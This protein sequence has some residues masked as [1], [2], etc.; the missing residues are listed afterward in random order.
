MVMCSKGWLLSGGM[1]TEGTSDMP[2]F[3]NDVTYVLPAI[4]FDLSGT[5][6]GTGTRVGVEVGVELGTGVGV[7]VR[8]DTKIDS[9]E[10]LVQH[11]DQTQTHGSDKDQGNG[12]NKENGWENGGFVDEEYLIHGCTRTWAMKRRYEIS[13]VYD[14]FKGKAMTKTTMSLS[15]IPGIN[16]IAAGTAVAGVTTSATSFGLLSVSLTGGGQTLLSS[17]STLS[18]SS[19]SSSSSLGSTITQ[20]FNTSLQYTLSMH[21]I[22]TSFQY[23]LIS[24][25]PQYILCILRVILSYIPINASYQHPLVTDVLSTG[26]I[27]IIIVTIVIASHSSWPNYW[28]IPCCR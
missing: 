5:R 4:G 20:P 21:P 9:S 28:R 14:E 19:S 10:V 23:N 25:V 18:S 6:V 16:T 13:S 7:G 15:S 12:S 8:G 24:F 17:S 1:Q 22:N 3:K 26:F 11:N 27:F 2:R